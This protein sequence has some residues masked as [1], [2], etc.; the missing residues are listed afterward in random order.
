MVRDKIVSFF[1]RMFAETPTPTERKVQVKHTE[2]TLSGWV[3]GEDRCMK[4]KE[5]ASSH[6]FLCFYILILYMFN[7]I[8]IFSSVPS[9]QMKVDN[10]PVLPPTAMF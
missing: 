10:V 6:M 4:S 2:N 5:S 7:D 8:Q 9:T 1:S 3:S